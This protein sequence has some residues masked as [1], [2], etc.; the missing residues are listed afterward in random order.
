MD[1]LQDC[2][3]E[4]VACKPT[5]P[6]N[7][8]EKLSAALVSSRVCVGRSGLVRKWSG[9]SVEILQPPLDHHL[10]V[11]HLGGPK[12]VRRISEGNQSPWIDIANEALTI[13]PS[14]AQYRWHILG[15]VDF[16]HLYVDP[17]RLKHAIEADF[18]RDHTDV[19]LTEAVGVTDPLLAELIKTLVEEVASGAN[20]HGAY[21]DRVLDLAVAHLALHH[22]TM[23]AATT[24]A[25]HALAP[26]RLRE[27]LSFVEAHISEPIQ[28]DDLARVAKLSRYH[29]SRAFQNA[30]GESPLAFVRRRR[31]ETAKQMLKSTEDPLSLVAQRCGFLCQSHFSANFRKFTGRTPTVYRALGSQGGTD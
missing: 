21:F 15:P 31:L 16:A 25:R 19:K 8:G 29:F 2:G 10:V 23:R 7:W 24:H 13:V 28:L 18:D 27:V 14:G 22:S 9:Q 4:G 20:D 3:L 11:L 17:D 6:A 5:S 12:R 26:K 1:E 30:I